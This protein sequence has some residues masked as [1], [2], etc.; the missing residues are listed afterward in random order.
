MR[1]KNRYLLLRI[2]LQSHTLNND[3]SSTRSTA[4]PTTFTATASAN[5]N[6][7]THV[8]TTITTCS[9]PKI[10]INT[11][12]S[13][14]SDSSKIK[15]IDF[16]KQDEECHSTH[17]SIQVEPETS[18]YTQITAILINSHICQ[19]IWHLFGDVGVAKCMVS[20]KYYNPYTHTAIIR[21]NREALYKMK[22]SI[23]HV[24]NLGKKGFLGSFYL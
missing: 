5:T 18:L 2:N 7:A 22:V 10:T 9:T 1:L 6:T 14:Q 17:T 13:I 23:H 21:V 24:T 11:S 4:T 3:V 15:T 12:L 16:E 19:S 20:C 8:N